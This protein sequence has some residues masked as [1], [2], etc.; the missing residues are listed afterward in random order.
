MFTEKSRNKQKKTSKEA[1]EG[2]KDLTYREAKI[3][4]TSNFCSKDMQ[5]KKEVRKI[6]C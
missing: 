4:I 2:E 1:R 3:K 5:T 6:K